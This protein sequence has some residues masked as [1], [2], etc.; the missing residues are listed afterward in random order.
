MTVNKTA[1]TA[2]IA[3]V[4]SYLYS[5]IAVVY[6]VAHLGWWR[7]LWPE[8]VQ[9]GTCTHIGDRSRTQFETGM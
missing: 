4:E 1:D 9:S 7:S 8:S 2:A 5:A 6:I 3:T